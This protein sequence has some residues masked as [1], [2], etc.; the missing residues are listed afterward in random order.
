LRRRC[1]GLHTV[2]I[3]RR[4]RAGQLRF[5]KDTRSHACYATKQKRPLRDFPRRLPLLQPIRLFGIPM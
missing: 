3:K 4:L 5:D 1:Y 2:M